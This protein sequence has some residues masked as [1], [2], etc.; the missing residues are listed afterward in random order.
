MGSSRIEENLLETT[1]EQELDGNDA[2]KLVP[3]TESIRYR[4]RAQSAEK[5]S[6][7]LAEQLAEANQRIARM[8]Q[9]VSDLQ[10]EQKL[11]C[12]LVAAGAVDLEAAV[13]KMRESELS[14]SQAAAIGHGNAERLLKTVSTNKDS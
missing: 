1:E 12:K 11:A 5:K 6:E 10:T 3:V 9:D 4:K 14:V 8:S 2:T 13:L 7:S